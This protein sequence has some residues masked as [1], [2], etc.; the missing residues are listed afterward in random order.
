VNAKI[1]APKIES[2]Q[3]GIR[4]RS[5]I[6]VFSQTAPTILVKFNHFTAT[7]SLNKTALSISSRI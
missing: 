2:V 6:V 3:M 4:K 7:I 1:L 5:G